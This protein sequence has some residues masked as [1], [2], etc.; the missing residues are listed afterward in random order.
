M[1][2][3]QKHPIQEFAEENDHDSEGDP[4]DG[5][6][7]IEPSNG[8]PEFLSDLVLYV[9]RKVREDPSFC[10]TP[11]AQALAEVDLFR[12][13]PELLTFPTIPFVD[14]FT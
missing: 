7:Q 2:N 10:E 6:L 14:D 11:I 4:E 1:T 8:L 3:R 9:G 5:A 13:E 12:R